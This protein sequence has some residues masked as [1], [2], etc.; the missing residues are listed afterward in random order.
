MKEVKRHPTT[1]ER[2]KFWDEVFVEE[3]LSHIRVGTSTRTWKLLREF[4]QRMPKKAL[5]KLIGENFLVV[6]VDRAKVENIGCPQQVVLLNRHFLSEL[7]EKE[8]ISVLAHEFAHIALDHPSLVPPEEAERI[9]READELA[10]KW[11]F[12][13][14][15]RLYHREV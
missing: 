13:E 8:A 6:E 5:K 9:Q 4:A 1:K 11:G 12:A 3:F 7:S 15:I 10:S 14:E 2:K